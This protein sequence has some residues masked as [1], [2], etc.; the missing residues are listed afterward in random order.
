MIRMIYE[1]LLQR[2]CDMFSFDHKNATKNIR[3]CACIMSQ[4]NGKCASCGNECDK[5]KSGSCYF[6]CK[7]CRDKQNKKR[8]TTSLVEQNVD[9]VAPTSSNQ[10]HISSS[11]S[12]SKFTVE[13]SITQEASREVVVEKVIQLDNNTKITTTERLKCTLTSKQVTE[14]NQVIQQTQVETIVQLAEPCESEL[15]YL[16][17]KQHAELHPDANNSKYDFQY[18]LEM[19]THRHLPTL[20]QNLGDIEKEIQER[21]T[22]ISRRPKSIAEQYFNEIHHPDVTREQGQVISELNDYECVKAYL[23]GFS[24]E[25]WN[26]VARYDIG[27]RIENLILTDQLLPSTVIQ[28]SSAQVVQLQKLNI[29]YQEFLFFEPIPKPLKQV[30]NWNHKP[31]ASKKADMEYD[32]YIEFRCA[33]LHAPDISNN[34]N[35][36]IHASQLV[37]DIPIDSRILLPFWKR[38]HGQTCQQMPDIT[39]VPKMLDTFSPVVSWTNV[40]QNVL[41]SDMGNLNRSIIPFTEHKNSDKSITTMCNALQQLQRH[42]AQ[43]RPPG[44]STFI[45]LQQQFEQ[46]WK[47]ASPYMSQRGQKRAVSLRLYN[48]V[49]QLER[50]LDDLSSRWPP[51]MDKCFNVCFKDDLSSVQMLRSWLKRVPCPSL[52]RRLRDIEEM[53]GEDVIKKKSKCETKDDQDSYMSDP[54]DIQYLQQQL[55]ERVETARLCNRPSMT[56]REQQKIHQRLFGRRN[57]LE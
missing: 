55:D 56:E 24:P 32:P 23:L 2:I 13:Q 14:V 25:D 31:I 53:T 27:R 38:K 42:V 30:I 35:K 29:C 40:F 3:L 8:K 15:Y 12:E 57:S 36:P 33:V 20:Q 28:V 5:K 45:M 46:L 21:K 10:Q 19:W 18:D 51:R 6:R 17:K 47:E 41:T 52:K 4:Q 54:S 9:T 26:D 34:P 1:N 50:N 49:L 43:E 44:H 7:T 22:R 48:D 37:T 39:G 11:S 16:W